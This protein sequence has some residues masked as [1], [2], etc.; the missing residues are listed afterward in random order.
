MPL[1]TVY[2]KTAEG[3]AKCIIDVKEVDFFIGLGAQ[4]TKTERIK[5]GVQEEQKDRQEES[6]EATTEAG[7]NEKESEIKPDKGFGK[8]GSVEWHTNYVR[9]FEEIDHIKQYAKDVTGKALRG[10]F[11]NIDNA[12][13]AAVRQIK[14][15]LGDDG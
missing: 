2:F 7:E 8:V 15:H 11:R 9:S 1:T 3:F 6:Q 12:K 14:E 5:N 13:T 10:F 4:F